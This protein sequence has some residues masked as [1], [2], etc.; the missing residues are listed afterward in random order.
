V[1]LTH[2]YHY[3]L[4]WEWYE[5]L[6]VVGPILILWWFSRVARARQWRNLALM[7]RALVVYEIVYFS[8]A[9]VLAIPARFESLARLQPQRSLYLLYILL[10]LFSGG[11]LA[12]YVVKNRVWR[13]LALFVPLCAGMFIAQ[14]A[15][16]P[17]SA[18][19]EWPGAKP[20]NQ[21][22]QAFLWVRQNT[23]EGAIFALDPAH[24][25]IPG[26][27]ENGFRALA[28]RSRLADAVKDSGA[29]TMFPPLAEEWLRQVQ[30]QKGW[31]ALH[32]ADFQRL[33]A[34]YGVNWV[35]VQQPA[36]SA[37]TCPYQ[38]EAVLVCRLN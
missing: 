6:G 14:R 5:L 31:K 34:K 3:V 4:K 9:V 32:L 1:A 8:A 30:A 19:I 7:C 16:F 18:H 11:F 21:W 35:I 24:M 27:D 13:W 25:D 10:I 38:N 33:Q 17:A 12:E 22:V 36:G 20:K 28:Q 23:P 37:L 2:A 26:E 29:V 15:L